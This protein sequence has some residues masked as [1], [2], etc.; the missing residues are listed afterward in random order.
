MIGDGANDT[1]ALKVAD[2]GISFVKNSSP[3]AKRVSGILINDLADLLT[4]V[5]S[6]RTMKWQVKYLM[7]FR[8]T[9]LTSMMLMLYAW[10]LN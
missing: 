10:I 8:V 5:Q 1:V 6:A 3:L 7:L 9:M 2:V 4:I